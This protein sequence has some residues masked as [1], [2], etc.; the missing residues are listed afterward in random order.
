MIA[1]CSSSGIEAASRALAG[2]ISEE[3]LTAEY[4]LPNAFDTRVVEVISKAVSDEA[5]R[6]GLNRK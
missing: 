5:I 3:E 2:V 6:L 4:V 1:L